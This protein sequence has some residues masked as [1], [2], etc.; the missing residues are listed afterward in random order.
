[1][2]SQ[3]TEYALRAMVCLAQTPDELAAAPTLA[4]QTRVPANYLAKVLQQ[5]AAAG[6]V[7]GRRG[8]GGGYRLAKPAEQITLFDIVTAMGTVRPDGSLPDGDGPSDHCLR[9][10]EHKLREATNAVTSVFRGVTLDEL[11]AGSPSASAA[12]R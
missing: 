9:L 3:T 8:V 12:A 6:L 4:R 10:L 5:L 7:N 1:M 2:F 11:V